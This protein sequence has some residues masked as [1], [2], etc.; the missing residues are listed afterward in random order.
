MLLL[1]RHVQRPHRLLTD[2]QMAEHRASSRTAQAAIEQ[3]CLQ[4]AAAYRLH[5]SK[6]STG[7]CR[8]ETSGSSIQDNSRDRAGACFVLFRFVSVSLS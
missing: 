5:M 3:I 1:A 6:D 2:A 7:C 8:T 4:A